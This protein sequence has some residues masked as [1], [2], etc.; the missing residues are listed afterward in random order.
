MYLQ[1]YLFFCLNFVLFRRC[2]YGSLRRC[3]CRSILCYIRIRLFSS[4]ILHIS[5]FKTLKLSQSQK[6][7]I[8][9]IIGWGEVSH[10]S[11]STTGNR[12]HWRTTTIDSERDAV[13]GKDCG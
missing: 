5:H 4:P 1:K 9:D 7:N 13:E 3:I 2:T 12:L 8:P 11:M 6:S 10:V